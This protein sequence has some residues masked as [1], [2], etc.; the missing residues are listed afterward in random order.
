MLNA[1]AIAKQILLILIIYSY[2]LFVWFLIAG[3]HAY[4]YPG[5]VFFGLAD[6]FSP[7]S[8][9]TVVRSSRKKLNVFAYRPAN[10]WDKPRLGA[11]TKALEENLQRPLVCRLGSVPL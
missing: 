1:R 8:P 4:G 2:F 11:G 10:L 5:E 6:C 7:P 9:E 3:G